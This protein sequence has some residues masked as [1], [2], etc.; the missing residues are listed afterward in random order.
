MN[1]LMIIITWDDSSE[2][3]NFKRLEE[4]VKMEPILVK[5]K[6]KTN[7][8]IINGSISQT[9]GYVLEMDLENKRVISSCR[10][11]YSLEFL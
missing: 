10:E 6:K 4:T 5:K 3:D 8:S 2:K 1:Y 9:N 7:L 11:V